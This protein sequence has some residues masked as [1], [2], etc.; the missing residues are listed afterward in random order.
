MTEPSLAL[1]STIRS[2]LIA[3]PALTDLVPAAMI[4]DR[5]ARPEADAMMIVGT[6]NTLYADEYETYA[7][8][9]YLDIHVWAREDD[10]RTCKE[11]AHLVREA[12][13][14]APWPAGTYMVHGVSITSKFIRDPSGEFSHG[15]VGVSATMMRRAA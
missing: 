3:N 9:A 14:N 11:I 12:L 5:H 13:K 6:G 4:L 2:R 8:Q 15:V 1:Q 10:F 7:D